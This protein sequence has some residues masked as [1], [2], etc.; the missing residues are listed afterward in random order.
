MFFE[1]GRWLFVM[2]F[3]MFVC[4]FNGCSRWEIEGQV[5]CMKSNGQA[6][7]DGKGVSTRKKR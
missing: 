3:V 6:T 7:V 5:D 4:C 2:A 1:L